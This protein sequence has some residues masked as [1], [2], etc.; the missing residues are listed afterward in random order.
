MYTPVG[1]SPIGAKKCR[2]EEAQMQD[3]QGDESNPVCEEC[4]CR[5]FSFA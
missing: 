5:I 2:A 1:R 4:S 3:S